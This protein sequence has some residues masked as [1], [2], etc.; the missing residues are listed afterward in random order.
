MDDFGLM[1][2]GATTGRRLIGLGGRGGVAG[3]GDSSCCPGKEAE[4]ALSNVSAVD[5]REGGRSSGES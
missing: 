5:W 4:T 2:R 1:S 3:R